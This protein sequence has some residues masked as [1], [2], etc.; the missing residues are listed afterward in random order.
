MATLLPPP[1]GTGFVE[2][3]VLFNPDTGELKVKAPPGA[4][5]LALSML[6]IAKR[7]IMEKIFATPRAVVPVR[8]FPRIS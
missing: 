2:V 7:Q 8:A 4:L 1:A 3:I 6:D 5:M